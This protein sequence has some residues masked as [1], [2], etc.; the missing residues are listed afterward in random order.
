MHSD[1]QKMANATGASITPTKTAACAVC[2]CA[3]CLRLIRCRILASLRKTETKA[4]VCQD[5]KKSELRFR[6]CGRSPL[7]PLLIPQLLIFSGDSRGPLKQ[8][9]P[10][11]GVGDLLHC[12]KAARVAR[13]FWY[14][15]KKFSE[16]GP[17]NSRGGWGI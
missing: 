14:K 13:A 8:P 16:G 9:R 10:G 2:C 15:K 11:V 3:C 17:K 7:I 4:C 12:L 5:R 1:A 6:R